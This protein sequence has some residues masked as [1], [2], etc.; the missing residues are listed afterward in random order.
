MRDAPIGGT[1]LRCSCLR[2]NDGGWFDRLTMSG[3]S[4]E[5]S[6]LRCAPLEMTTTRIPRR[7]RALLRRCDSPVTWIPAF[8]GMTGQ[9]ARFLPP[10]ERR[11]TLPAFPR[12]AMVGSSPIADR[13]DALGVERFDRLTMSGHLPLAY[14]EI[15]RLRCAPLEMTTT[16]IPRRPR[17]LL[18]RCDLP[19][20]WIIGQ[21]SNGQLEH[22]PVVREHP[23]VQHVG[24]RLVTRR[25]VA[26]GG[27]S[28]GSPLSGSLSPESSAA[29]LD[30]AVIE[31]PLEM[32]TTRIP[33]R[34]RALLRRCDLPVTCIPACAGMTGQGARS[35][36]PPRCLPP[37]NDE[38]YTPYPVR[39]TAAS[40]RAMRVGSRGAADSASMH[41]R[42]SSRFFT[43]RTTVPMPSIESA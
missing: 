3:L 17:A 39:P 22:L 19:V 27:G 40:M 21:P 1:G 4:R 13:N 20:T 38:V 31:A 6:R 28:T 35:T 43:P 34:P 25:K 23:G 5:I 18:R 12:Q 32:T 8:A 7:P 37:R 33:R 42:S 10:Q 29:I 26:T 30:S 11:A 16:R 15:S 14:R 41:S 24:L 36:R 2:G 9:G